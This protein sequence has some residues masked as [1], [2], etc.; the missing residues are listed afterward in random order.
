[1]RNLLDFNKSLSP[2]MYI[3]GLPMSNLYQ[4]SQCKTSITILKLNNKIHAVPAPL[5]DTPYIQKLYFG[6]SDYH[7]KTHK[8]CL[9][10]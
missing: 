10:A 5:K 1:M 2:R 3:I 8:N 9:L 6:P 7:I 4:L